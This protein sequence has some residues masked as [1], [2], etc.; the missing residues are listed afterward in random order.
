MFGYYTGKGLVW[1]WSEP[2]GRGGDSVRGGGTG[3][4]TETNCENLKSRSLERYLD[5]LYGKRWKPNGL[6]ILLSLSFSLFAR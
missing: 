5:Q 4:R 2:L 6:S 1:K 3:Q